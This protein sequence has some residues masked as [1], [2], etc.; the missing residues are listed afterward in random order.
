MHFIILNHVSL[1]S[2]SLTFVIAPLY[3]HAC[4]CAD[5]N[6]LN[7]KVFRN[8]IMCK[9]WLYGLVNENVGYLKWFAFSL[10]E[11]W[12]SMKKN[13]SIFL[14]CF[15]SKHEYILFYGVTRLWVKYHDPVNKPSPQIRV[16]SSND[17]ISCCCMVEWTSFQFHSQSPEFVPNAIWHAMD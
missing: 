10:L 6:Y 3:V 8:L 12:S 1:S 9:Y 16:E 2:Q 13:H 5:H 14:F 7:E 15:S 17:N 11:A 4:T